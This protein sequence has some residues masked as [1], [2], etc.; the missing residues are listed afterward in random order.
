MFV[1]TLVRGES[2]PI[3]GLTGFDVLQGSYPRITHQG[4]KGL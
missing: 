4:F 3:K 1:R 2:Q